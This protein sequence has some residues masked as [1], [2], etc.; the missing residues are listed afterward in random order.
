MHESISRCQGRRHGENLIWYSK[1]SESPV[2]S[3]TNTLFALSRQTLSGGALFRKYLLNGLQQDFER[4]LALFPFQLGSKQL[5]TTLGSHDEATATHRWLG[6]VKFV[7]VL[8]REG[9]VTLRIVHECDLRMLDIEVLPDEITVD[10]P[11]KLLQIAGPTMQSINVGPGMLGVCFE[12]LAQIM[13]MQGL[14]LRSKQ[15][16][17][18]LIDIHNA[19]WSSSTHKDL[20]CHKKP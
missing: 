1:K 15:K 17:E 9:I 18:I 10:S 4:G 2:G 20:N 12:R 19:G 6:L 5:S 11:V 16:V 7:G 14:S 3:S 13:N 8:Y